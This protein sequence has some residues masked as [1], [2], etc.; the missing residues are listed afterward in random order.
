MRE[1][2]SRLSVRRYVRTYVRTYVHT[3]WERPRGRN[4]EPEKGARELVEERRGQQRERTSQLAL[5]G[6]RA[7]F[8]RWWT[9]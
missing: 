4:T 9:A 6:E 5:D 1:S 2:H 3:G 8:L 7:C